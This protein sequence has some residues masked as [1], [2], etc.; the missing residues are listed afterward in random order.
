[1]KNP[2]KNSVEG[3]G[4]EERVRKAVE[5]FPGGLVVKDLVLSLGSLLRC[6]FKP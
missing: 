3:K 2:W 5:E 1:M 6:R 4:I